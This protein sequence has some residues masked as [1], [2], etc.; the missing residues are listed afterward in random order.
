MR[1][2]APNG[3]ARLVLG[4]ALPRFIDT[5]PD[6]QLEVLSRNH[7]PDFVNERIDAAL[8]IGEVPELDIVARPVGKIPHITVAAPSY[9][10]HSGIPDTPDDLKQHRCLPILS[11][12]TGRNLPWHFRVEGQTVS[13]PVQGPLSFEAPEAAVAAASRGAGILQ[14]ASYLVY[15]E[16]RSGRLVPVL[17]AARPK[18]LDM[19][20]VHQKH[21]LKP[22]KLRVFE[23]FIIDLNPQTRRKWG[24]KQID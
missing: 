14:L 5:Y 24:V 21:R 3:L 23:E 22:R 18:A 7:V 6:I 17:E 13:V 20:I 15:E 10:A 2:Q 9:L 11:S 19:H 4:P 8:V 1:V 12:V 16:V